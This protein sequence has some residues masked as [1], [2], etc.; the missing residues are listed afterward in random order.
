MVDEWKPIAFVEWMQDDDK[1]NN[2]MSMYED[3]IVIPGSD[4][5]CKVCAKK[6]TVRIGSRIYVYA[7]GDVTVATVRGI[8]WGGNHWFSQDDEFHL[9]IDVPGET[10]DGNVITKRCHTWANWICN[11]HR[12]AQV[13][14]LR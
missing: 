1:V 2:R 11:R 5:M 8:H 13:S 12:D 6:K 10:E 7:G 4:R 3:E 14:S 9:D